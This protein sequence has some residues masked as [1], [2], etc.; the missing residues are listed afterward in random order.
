MKNAVPVFRFR[1][2]LVNDDLNL[3]MESCRDA[4]GIMSSTPIASHAADVSTE[5]NLALVRASVCHRTIP[6]VWQSFWQI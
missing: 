4:A 2:S 6:E 3:L 1:V 5:N